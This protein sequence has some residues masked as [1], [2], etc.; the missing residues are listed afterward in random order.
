MNEEEG[1]DMVEMK[2]GLGQSRC[3]AWEEYRGEEEEKGKDSSVY[4]E[5]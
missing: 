1:G 5:G 2:G 3:S 4:W